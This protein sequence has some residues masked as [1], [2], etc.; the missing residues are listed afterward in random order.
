LTKTANPTDLFL[1]TPLLLI[2]LCAT[3]TLPTTVGCA[4]VAPPTPYGPTPSARQLKWHE[5]EVYGMVN[6]S[7]IT[8]YGKE[9]GYGDEDPAKFN[10]TEF[11]ARQIARAARAAGIKLLV[12]DAKHHGGFCLWPSKY[13]DTYTVKNTPWR[14]GKG[15]MIKELSDAGRAEGIRVGIYLSPW[16]RN[17]KDYGKPE[18]VAYY[19]N[20]L[21]ELLTNYGEIDEIWFDGANGG[22]GYYGGAKCTRTISANYYQWKKVMEIVRGAQPNAVCFNRE[23]IRWVGNES[24]DGGDPCW[25]AVNDPEDPAY[26]I[27]NRNGKYW[28][29]AEAD[30]PLRNGWFWHPGGQT[31]SPAYLVN[32]YFATVGRNCAMDVGIAPDRRGLIDEPDTAALKGFGERIQAIF[33]TKLAQGARATA[34]NVRGN[35]QTYAAANVLNGKSRFKTYWATDDGVKDAE[36]TLDFGKPTEFSVVSLREPIQLGQR[37]D[38]WAL[39]S[40]QDSQWQEFATGTGIGARRLWR[41]QSITSDKLR[42][43][44]INASA[45]PA[46]SEVGV[47]LEPQAGRKESGALV[48][49]HIKL[50]LSKKDWK[51]V[52]FS[53]EGEGTGLASHAIDGKPT[54]F[55]HTH[56]AAG[57]QPPPQSLTV[58]MGKEQE[59]TGFLYLPRQDNCAVGNVT[60]YAFAISVGGQAWTEV[61]QGEFGNI[62]ANPVQQKVKLDKP[63]TARYFKFT[64][65]GALDGC[66]NA[67]EIGVL[68]K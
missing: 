30:F 2:A 48:P 37:I 43:R 67:A 45:S 27:G 1:K 62:A 22:D 46:I 61:A 54:T 25:G 66:A 50:G 29:P 26:T 7:T 41:G 18:Y 13:N 10:P 5:L 34:S 65:S 8:Y 63:V 35:A 36:L 9:W 31:K 38:T 42:L 23:D 19:Q 56:T 47:Y 12:I 51:V 28:M 52:S 21:R 60:H 64:A 68:A 40:W 33:N 44:L 11:D 39:D 6:F 14:G 24:G 17:H 3:S 53:A 49:G 15:D 55:W 57:R 59:L 58:D 16:D 20:Q 32:R 4:A